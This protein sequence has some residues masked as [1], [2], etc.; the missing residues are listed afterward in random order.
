M[1]LKLLVIISLF[2]TNKSFSQVYVPFQFGNTRWSYMKTN[3]FGS[4]PYFYFSKDTNSIYYNGNKYWKIEKQTSPIYAP[5][6]SYGYIFDD[7]LSKKVFYYSNSSG[8]S[9]LLYD[10]SVSI[11]DTINSIGN[12][13]TLDTVIVDSIKFI[14]S[15]SI[16]R[17]H[18]Y[19]HSIQ[20]TNP[21]SK[22]WIEG[23]GSYYDLFYPSIT[24]PDPTYNLICYQYKS[25]TLYPD[26]LNGANTCN[27]FLTS[28]NNYENNLISIFPN[29]TRNT[30]FIKPNITTQITNY[31][32]YN[33]IGS[34]IKNEQLKNYTINIQD[35]PTGI[36]YLQ[37]QTETG[38]QTT[39]IIKQ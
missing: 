21:Q 12:P 33:T 38:N 3:T 8:L 2:F 36:Y 1:K 31:K 34:I 15:N 30:I 27:S 24:L 6:T 25:N 4:T 11:G 22:I 28:V 19:L 35:Q 26:T 10:F 16:S 7:T 32:L 17:K 9:N 5:S 39:K 23:I 13:I 29:P 37:L 14:S 20:T 18:I